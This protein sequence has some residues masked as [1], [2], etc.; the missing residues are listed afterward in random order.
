MGWDAANWFK[1]RRLLTPS[2]LGAY[3]YFQNRAFAVLQRLDVLL[4][5]N[6]LPV[7]FQDQ[8]EMC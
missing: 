5:S 2:A 6:V 1:K 4:I 8:Q 3:A 7:F